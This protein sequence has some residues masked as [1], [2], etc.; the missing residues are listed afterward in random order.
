MTQAM[1]I[2]TEKQWDSSNHMFQK[3]IIIIFKKYHYNVKGQIQEGL[4]IMTKSKTR[5]NGKKLFKC[6]RGT[7]NSNNRL[8]VFLKDKI[9]S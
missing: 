3:C 2:K 8:L 5:L 6:R 7:I 9:N 1:K 4:Q